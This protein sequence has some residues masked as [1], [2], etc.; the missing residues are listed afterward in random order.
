MA[1]PIAYGRVVPVGGIP[2]IDGGVADAIPFE[3]ALALA[4]ARVIVVTTRPNGYR[5]K[6]SRLNALFR[7]NYPNFP[8]LWPVLANRWQ[9][10][11]RAI[12]KLEALERQGRVQVIRPVRTL[13]AARMT[14]DR[15]RI[16]ETLAL[17][18]DAARA[19]L[20]SDGA[21]ALA[22]AVT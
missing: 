1:L 17:G 3:P 11:N 5:K 13:P 10:Y 14:R 8:A 12:A 9:T 2:Y 15:R 4:P 22:S 18:R 21:T 7:Y 20:S 19:F 16:V 6:P